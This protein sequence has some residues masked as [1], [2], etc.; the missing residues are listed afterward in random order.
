LHLP[1]RL[2]WPACS[3]MM[4]PA[5]ISAAKG[6]VIV[7][8]KIQRKISDASTALP[9][10]DLDDLDDLDDQPTDAVQGV[11]SAAILGDDL[12]AS[13]SWNQRSGCGEKAPK[14][15]SAPVASP[16]GFDGVLSAAILGD[17]LQASWSWN[18]R[19]GFGEKAP[20]LPS[21]PVASPAGFVGVPSAAILGD[22]LQASWSWH[23]RSSGVGKMGTT[24]KKGLSD[25][26]V[27]SISCK[28][29]PRANDAPSS[30]VA[31]HAADRARAWQWR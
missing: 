28:K 29:Q 19:S 27:P 6:E 23:Q 8:D 10:D 5:D 22:D 2:R 26:D 31:G 1:A 21:A 30:A 17:D 9:E 18:Q 14:L 4:A 20:K 7:I 24:G 16:A 3:S 12:Q 11:L 25:K 13:W 15:P